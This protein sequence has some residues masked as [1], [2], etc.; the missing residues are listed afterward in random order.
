MR[1]YSRLFPLLVAAARDAVKEY[2]YKP[3]LLNGNPVEVVTQVDVIFRWR[4]KKGLHYRLCGC[5]SSTAPCGRGS[6]DVRRTVQKPKGAGRGPALLMRRLSFATVSKSE[7]YWKGGS[8]RSYG[9][10]VT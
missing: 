6:C 4:I 7:Y 3:T 5:L 9:R 8:E 2:V 1:F 10:L